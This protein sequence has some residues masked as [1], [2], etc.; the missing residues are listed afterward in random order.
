MNKKTLNSLFTWESLVSLQ[1]ATTVV[2]LVPNVLTFLIGSSFQPYEKWVAFII[3]LL[4]S[5][6]VAFQASGKSV[7]KWILA[8]LNGFFIFASAVGLTEALGSG[9]KTGMAQSGGGLPFFHSWYP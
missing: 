6:L 7:T 2:V 8:I 5:F 9:A 4:L 1:G 3:A